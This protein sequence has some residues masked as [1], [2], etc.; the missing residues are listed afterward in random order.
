[1]IEYLRKNGLDLGGLWNVLLKVHGNFQE[2]S[3]CKL[4]CV[5]CCALW[6]WDAAWSLNTL[7]CSCLSASCKALIL[8]GGE[9]S[10]GLHRGGSPFR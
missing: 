5:V 3:C 2:G 7:R 9:L 8:L 4:Y 1:M 6:L 10:R